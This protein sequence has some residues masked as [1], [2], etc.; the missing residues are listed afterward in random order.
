MSPT[1][2]FFGGLVLGVG[3]CMMLACLVLIAIADAEDEA[4]WRV[5]HDVKFTRAPRSVE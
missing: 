5:Q 1:A 3:V 2:Y 4:R